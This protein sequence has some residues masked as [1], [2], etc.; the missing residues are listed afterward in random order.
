MIAKTLIKILEK[1]P[2]ANVIIYDG[3]KNRDITHVKQFYKLNEF[4]LSN[5]LMIDANQIG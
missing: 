4:E 5:D 2:D 3:I 1:N